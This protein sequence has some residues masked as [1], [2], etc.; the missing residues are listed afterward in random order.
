MILQSL[1]DYYG[2]L[3]KADKLPRPG[4]CRVKVSYALNI[5]ETGELIGVIPLK[6]PAVVGKKTVYMPQSMEVPEQ[7]KK[8][9]GINSNFLCENSGYILGIDNKGKPDR[10]IKCFKEFCELHRNILHNVDSS[11]AKG[12]LGYI[13]SWQP[14]M[15][16]KN[17]ILKDYLDDILTGVNLVMYLNGVGYIHD[18]P[19]IRKAWEAY[20]NKK[21]N[22]ATEM[23][24]LVTGEMSPIARLHP[25][26]KGVRGAQAT[27]A[28]IVSFNDRAYESYGRT[29]DQG[30]N[31]PVSEKAAFAYTTALNS[32]IDDKSHSVYMGDTTVVFWADSRNP[33]YHDLFNFLLMPDNQ[34]DTAERTNDKGSSML[35]REV[36]RKIASGMP[37]DEANSLIDPNVRFFI[38]GLSPNAA[39]LSVRFFLNDS[40]SVFIN[41]IMSHYNNMEIIKSPSDFQYVPLWK[42]MLET[43]SPS[44]KD[45]AASPL[46]TGTVL[47]A[48][49]AGLPY[50]AAL[51][52]A[53][54]IRIRAERDVNRTKAGIIKAYLI[55]KHINNQKY[56][57][58]LTVALNPQSNNRSYVLGRLFAVLEK[59]QQDANPGIKATIKDRYFTSACATPSSVFPILLRLSN[60]HISKSEFG[61][62][63][64]NRIRDLMDKLQVDNNPF[65][66]HLTLDEQGIFILGYYHQQKA[67]YEK[68][69]KE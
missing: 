54:M 25:N 23:R 13:N 67:N 10:T 6:I 68:Q 19:I 60:H 36:F 8:T 41:R 46:L 48:I 22:N 35:I 55:Q 45:K 18:D 15:C 39:R 32:L 38:L 64:E 58:E 33:I 31:A 37:L 53:F 12:V 52:N 44:S 7:V 65:P 57:E 27:G 5:N 4:Y 49:L 51:Y 11:C 40:F 62:V 34:I 24:C 9:V 17:I 2:M 69:K 30:L 3:V 29:K 28:S 56:K 50:P 43:V 26:I 66:A 47:R 1:T 63:A 59:V 61:Y 16:D 14:E 21:D 20:I 42:L